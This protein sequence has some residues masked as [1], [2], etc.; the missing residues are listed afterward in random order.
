LL[1]ATDSAGRSWRF[2]LTD[3]SGGALGTRVLDVVAVPVRVS[4]RA[5]RRGDLLFLAVEPSTIE[6]L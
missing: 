5:S 2:L 6:R 3:P 1:V 4:G